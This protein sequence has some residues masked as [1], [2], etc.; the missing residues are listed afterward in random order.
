MNFDVD[1]NEE[2][3]IISILDGTVY[4]D[5]PEERVRQKYLKL[6]IY[7]YCYESK[8][9]DIEVPIYYG[10]SEMKDGNGHPI[11][12]DIVVY[13]SS[14]AKKKRDQ[15]KI[16]FIVECKAPD[17]VG[18]YNQL[19]SYIYNT[20]A[21]GGVWFNGNETEYEV[22]YYRRL[23]E[24]VNNLVSW[25]GLPRKGENWDVLGRRKK[26]E[27]HL[28][29]NIKAIFRLCH[30]KLHGR[31]TEED[32]LTMDMVR[33][34]LAK[35][36]DEE[37]EGEYPLFYCTP[38]E[39]NSESGIKAV[40]KRIESL[41]DEVKI[42]NGEIF[43]T[44]E[45][46]TVG[47]R[48]IC[49]VVT[50]LQDFQ[51]LSD[52]SD[53]V[54][55]DLMGA[56]YE[57]YTATYLKKRRGQFFTN[58]LVVE[59]MVSI[60]APKPEDIILDPAGGSGGFLT[61]ALRYV[62]NNIISS[63]STKVAKQ[64]QLDSFRTRLF[65][66]EASKRLVKVAK[67]A[68]ILNGDGHT[69][70]TQGD[71]LGPFLNFEENIIAKCYKE[72]PTMILTN[73]PFAGTGDGKISDDATLERFELGKK[74]CTIDG[75]YQS[76]DEFVFDGVPPEMLFVERC[77]QWLRP[78][79]SLGIVLPKGFLDTATYQSARSYM[80]KNCKILAVIN[81]NKNTF[82]PH[83]GVRTCIV[84]LQKY[85][86]NEP[87]NDYSIFMG[88]SNKIGQDSEGEPI[89]RYEANGDQTNEIDQDLSEIYCKYIDFK[90]GKL[91][92]SEFCFE[93]KLSSIDDNFRLNP[94]AHMPSLNQTLKNVANIEQND[95][96]NVISL[97]QMDK[98]IRIFKGP[99][100]K[101]ENLIVEN[102]G[103]RVEPYYTPSAILQDKG[104]SVKYLDLNRASEK[105]LRDLNKVRLHAGDIVITRSGSI[106]RVAIINSR[107]E[108]VIA[109]DDLIRVCIPDEDLRLYVYNYL[110]TKQAQDQMLLNEY[111]SI[112]Q[113]LEPVHISELLIPIP[114]D[115]SKI[116]SIVM[117]AKL[118]Y[119]KK[120]EAYELS[121]KTK[122]ILDNMIESLIQV[123]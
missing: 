16:D 6:L 92:E 102:L 121:V 30:N 18:G 63:K 7:D 105:Q 21:S 52:I 83:T 29:R 123:R 41:F 60:L 1:F 19:V 61:G 51:L 48:A 78:G 81:L 80:I 115:F 108:N 4:E 71:S 106:G 91:I 66:V 58:R 40:A 72:T 110:L 25:P 100:L 114:D 85:K 76:T 49:D 101:T 43:E 70:M 97:G 28:P 86:E 77:I 55:W 26:A 120:E 2:G 113:H 90:N 67:T 117:N 57:E 62:R 109:S 33:L 47:E 104:D 24:P 89:F 88:I 74:W 107:F 96:W 37:R 95:G 27:L 94:Q 13:E 34:I 54:E 45:R 44:N 73:P 87:R 8:L 17:Q 42:L 38:E 75:K 12:A 23:H 111:G 103:E 15:G 14:V 10:S 39:Y 3:K 46:I 35:A 9:I 32:D 50:T 122:N 5:R 11:R 36:R 98:A 53:S 82:Q 116:H 79:G 59:F 119:E 65:M 68:M 84:F 93:V 56:A 31:G 22:A 20:S 118:S 69:G 64:R 112:Q 99:R